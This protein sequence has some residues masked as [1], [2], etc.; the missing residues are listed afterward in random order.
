MKRGVLPD[1][2]DP[3]HRAGIA[4]IGEGKLWL[5]CDVVIVESQNQ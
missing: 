2:M 3:S 5:Q 4:M 1:A